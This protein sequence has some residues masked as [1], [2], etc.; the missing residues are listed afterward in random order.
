M[1]D[2]RGAF[3]S[4]AAAAAGFVARAP[5]FVGCVLLVVVWAPTLPL[6]GTPDTWQLVINTVT[7][8]VTFLLVALLQ[9]AQARAE[10]ASNL[11][12][13]AIADGLADLMR[14]VADGDDPDPDRLRRDIED[15][16]R[17]S[18]IETDVSA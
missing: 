7:T 1:A 10:K 15:L 5:F 2:E 4:F 18:G 17:A 9:N 11:K 3:D 14:Y 13:N 6:F 12:L 8:I 16:K